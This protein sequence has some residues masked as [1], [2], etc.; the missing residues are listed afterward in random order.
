MC[1]PIEQRSYRHRWYALIGRSIFTA[2]TDGNRLK[3]WPSTRLVLCVLVIPVLSAGV[4]RTRIRQFSS[5]IEIFFG[6]KR[7]QNIWNNYSNDIAFGKIVRQLSATVLC[8]CVCR[9]QVHNWTLPTPPQGLSQQHGQSSEL[10]RAAHPKGIPS[11][12]HA[13]AK[14]TKKRWTFTQVKFELKMLF[15][16]PP[17]VDSFP[18]TICQSGRCP[19]FVW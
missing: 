13:M 12:R 10:V 1:V 6:I 14:F 3:A 7:N 9:C 17:L 2:S 5:S 15:A 11:R 19:R 8:V 4:V 18:M 16:L